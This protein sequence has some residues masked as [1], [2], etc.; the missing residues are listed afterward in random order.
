M[1]S[2]VMRQPR[3]A[4]LAAAQYERS[5]EAL[6]YLTRATDARGRRLQIIKL[7]LPKPMYYTQV[8]VEH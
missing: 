3:L 1:C 5:V 4:L 2:A 7:P 6:Q 8:G